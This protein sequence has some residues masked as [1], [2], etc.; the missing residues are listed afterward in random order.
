MGA[1]GGEVKS[2]Q[3]QRLRDEDKRGEGSSPQ[4]TGY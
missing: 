1:G 4:S 2:A 3:I